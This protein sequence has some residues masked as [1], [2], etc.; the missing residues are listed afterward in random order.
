MVGLYILEPTK[1]PKTPIPQ[2][3]SWM[4]WFKWRDSI[5][6]IRISKQSNPFMDHGHHSHTYNV[7]PCFS[8]VERWLLRDFWQKTEYPDLSHGCRDLNEEIRSILSCNPTPSWHEQHLP[9]ANNLKWH[10]RPAQWFS[11]GP[12]VVMA[13]RFRLPP[14]RPNNN[15]FN[16]L[17]FFIKW[18]L[19]CRIQ[20]LGFSSGV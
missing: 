16:F 11:A 17:N 6:Y 14:T 20:N 9:P 18:I 8:S 1:N 15:I 12:A 2:L 5:D 13:N 4:W 3:I 19:F 10:G 7:L